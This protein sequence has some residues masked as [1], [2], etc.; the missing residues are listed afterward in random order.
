MLFWTFIQKHLILSFMVLSEYFILWSV[1]PLLLLILLLLLLLDRAAVQGL[2][3]VI[4][5][6]SVQTPQPHNTNK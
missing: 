3:R 2:E 5:T 1:P 6:V 4:Y